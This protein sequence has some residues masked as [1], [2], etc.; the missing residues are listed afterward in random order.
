VTKPELPEPTAPAD[1]P[2]HEDTMDDAISWFT[3]RSKRE[4]VAA[5]A[6]D[7]GDNSVDPVDHRDHADLSDRVDPADPVAH[8]DD[9]DPGA[10]RQDTAGDELADAPLGDDRDPDAPLA[11]PHDEEVAVEHGE[12]VAIAD[13]TVTTDQPDAVTPRDRSF[14]ETDEVLPPPDAID[15]EAGS[16]DSADDDDD[17]PTRPAPVPVVTDRTD[18]SDRTDRDDTSDGA[19]GSQPPSSLFRDDPVP[20]DPVVPVAAAGVGA[21]GLGAFAA[22]R[23]ADETAVIDEDEVARRRAEEREER[24]RQL[25]KVQPLA[26]APAPVPYALPTTYKAFP[27]LGLLLLRLVT[28]GVV[29]IRGFMHA[30]DIAGLQKLWADHTILAPQAQTV[31]WVQTGLEVAI[32]VMLVFGLGTRIA[33]ALLAA[34]AGCLL[35]LML[36][37]A[38]NPFQA[39]LVGFIGEIEVLL[40]AVGIFFLTT[41]GGRA[42]IDGTIH[43]GRIDAKNDRLLA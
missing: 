40:A 2:G 1:R 25:G 8:V 4:P 13:D 34:L 32:A 21:A 7:G 36:W 17:D 11:D 33:G 20:V 30:M 28:A 41:G 14:N 9:V 37:G 26:S 23:S 6:T 15:T 29:G 5:K 24:D 10:D 31:A 3:G 39:G 43:K 16:D 38:A 42:A 18:S 12:P 22:S 19:D 27:T 35:G